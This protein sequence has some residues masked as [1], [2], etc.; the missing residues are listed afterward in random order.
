MKHAPQAGAFEGVDFVAPLI[1]WNAQGDSRP[2]SPP[3]ASRFVVALGFVYALKC[4]PSGRIFY[5]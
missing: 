2:P 3:H 4:A 5:G 1:L